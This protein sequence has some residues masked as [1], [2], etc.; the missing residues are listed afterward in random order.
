LDLGLKILK[1]KTSVV[2]TGE[3]IFKDEARGVFA[4]MGQGIE[5]VFVVHK[6]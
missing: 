5:E 1:K 3:F 4:G 2:Y 6:G